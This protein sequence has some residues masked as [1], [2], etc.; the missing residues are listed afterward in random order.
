EEPQ[1]PANQSIVQ[2][3]RRHHGGDIGIQIH[4]NSN[5]QL[6]TK[7]KPLRNRLMET[8][9]GLLGLQRRGDS[10]LCQDYL[11]GLMD[12]PFKV[13]DVMKQ[14]QWYFSATDYPSYIKDNDSSTAKS[15]A[16]EQ[17]IEDLIAGHGENAK[18]A[19]C[20]LEEDEDPEDAV[21]NVIDAEQPPKSLWGVLDTWIEHRLI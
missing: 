4:I 9:L 16:M 18:N 7:L 10:K 13:A 3:A 21:A 11:N 19:Y 17:W 8:R 12:D 2:E 1:T 15:A 20:G 14:M 6:R 5:V